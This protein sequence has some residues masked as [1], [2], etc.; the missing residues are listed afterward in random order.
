MKTVTICGSMRFSK[1]MQQIALELE[2][3]RGWCVLPPIGGA[4]VTLS[5]EALE[6]LAEAHYKKID[7]SDAVYVVNIDGYIG[8]SVAQELQYAKNRGKEIIF[9][10]AR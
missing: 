5:E 8:K 9:H 10:E 3:K 6:R 7:L 2:T 4:D 1:Q